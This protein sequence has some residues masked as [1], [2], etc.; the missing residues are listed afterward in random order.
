MQS[1]YIV[2]SY[3]SIQT[4]KVEVINVC[5]VVYISSNRPVLFLMWPLSDLLYRCT[6][7]IAVPSNS[8]ITIM[9]LDLDLEC[10]Y[11]TLKLTVNDAAPF[12]ELCSKSKQSNITTIAAQ[13]DPFTLK[14][15]F[16]SDGSIARKGFF[17]KIFLNWTATTTT[18]TPTTTTAANNYDSC[19]YLLSIIF[20]LSLL[21]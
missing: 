13:K 6:Y 19:E 2:K 7:T 11:D 15:H 18:A 4:H 8:P 21:I 1:A 10:P 9:I 3:G 5:F 12:R 16:A 17:I 20:P 14:A